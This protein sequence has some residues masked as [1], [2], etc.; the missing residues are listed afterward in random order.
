MKLYNACNQGFDVGTNFI[1]TTSNGQLSAAGDSQVNVRSTER[2]DITIEPGKVDANGY[3]EV[4][5]TISADGE[6][7]IG[8]NALEI[9]GPSG[10]IA[11]YQIV[12]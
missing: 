3:N 8:G 10:K 7:N 1:I 5:F 12:D 4:R 11:D 2:L 6:S 9:S